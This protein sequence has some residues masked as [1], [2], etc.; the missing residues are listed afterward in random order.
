MGFSKHTGTGCHFLLPG[1]LP[2]QG[3]N[4]CLHSLLH[5]QVDSLPLSHL[6]TQ[7]APRSPLVSVSCFWIAES[8]PW[9]GKTSHLSV[10][11]NSTAQWSKAMTKLYGTLKGRDI[12]LPTK[13]HL[14]K[15]MVFP[16]VMCGCESWTIKSAERWRTDAFEL[17]CW[18]KL[19]R[20]PARRCNQSILKEINHE[21]SLEGLMLKLK[22]QYVGHLMWRTDSLEKPSCW[23]RLKA[24]EEGDNRGW[25]GWLAS[26]TRWTG[27]WAS[28][29]S[30][31]WTGKLG[32]LQSMG[33]QRAGHD[34]T[35]ELNSSTGIPSPPLGLFVVTLLKTHLTAFQDVWL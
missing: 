20:I 12:T 23:E 5:W 16:I 6:E 3:L 15:A 14:I 26:L 24:R 11:K 4:P 2:T 32:M 18:R 7:E 22:P 28:F 29:G 35:T 25:D 21:Y 8:T 27:V 33:F 10:K 34:W 17:W 9:G 19:L 13:V 1:N 31:W 30:W